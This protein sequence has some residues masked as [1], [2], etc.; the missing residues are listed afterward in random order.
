M[1]RS[2]KKLVLV[3]CMPRDACEHSSLEVVRKPPVENFLLARNS[4]RVADLLKA[5]RVIIIKPPFLWFTPNS[6]CALF[7]EDDRHL[8]GSTTSP[9]PWCVWLQ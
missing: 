8:R 6:S 1:L 7:G 5:L 9:G 2:E 4:R 3:R